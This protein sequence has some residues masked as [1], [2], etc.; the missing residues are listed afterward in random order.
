MNVRSNRI[1]A[2]AAVVAIGL[3]GAATAVSQARATVTYKLSAEK[4]K[5][6]FNTSTIRVK[7]GRVT[8]RMS[9]PSTIPHAVGIKGKG[10]GKTVRKNG[11][12]TYTATL[13]KGKSYTFY[14]PVGSHDT[15]GMRGT[16]IVR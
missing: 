14:C 1:I 5:L 10:K 2:G 8:L 15:A 11:V 12:S 7:A 6:K 4:A 3:G 16:L 13:Q 9:N